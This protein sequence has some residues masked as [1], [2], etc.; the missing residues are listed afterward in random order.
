MLGNFRVAIEAGLDKWRLAGS[1]LG[2]Y[3]STSSQNPPN[4]WKLV[5]VSRRLDQFLVT[6]IHSFVVDGQ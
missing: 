1:T 6:P 2:V 4:L 5:L 3:V